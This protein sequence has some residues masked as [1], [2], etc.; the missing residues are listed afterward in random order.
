MIKYEL[1][2]QIEA[3]MEDAIVLAVTHLKYDNDPTGNSPRMAILTRLLDIKAETGHLQDSD[4]VSTQELIRQEMIR[5]LIKLDPIG[6]YSDE[7]SLDN[8]VNSMTLEE[9][10]N[11]VVNAILEYEHFMNSN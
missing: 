4:I 7:D 2:K 5:L 10:I 11:E 1:V 8:K 6:C 3:L 9:S